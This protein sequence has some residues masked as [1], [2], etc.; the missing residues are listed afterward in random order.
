MRRE[1]RSSLRVLLKLLAEPAQS[2]LD[3]GTELRHF[4]CS[5]V[6]TLLISNNATCRR[7]L[8]VSNMFRKDDGNT[9]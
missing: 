6:A 2:D 9:C 3:D 1:V 4:W 5:S 8:L 7:L